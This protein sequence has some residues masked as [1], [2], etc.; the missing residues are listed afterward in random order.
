MCVVLINSELKFLDLIFLLDVGV[1]GV[2]GLIVVIV[3]VGVCILIGD[4]L[5]FGVVVL[6]CNCLVVCCLNCF[7]VCYI[8]VG[9]CGVC[10]ILFV[11]E[12]FVE[13]WL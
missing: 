2:I 3:G 11:W 13:S 4:G 1:V 10:R 5:G 7:Y 9:M 12:I 6:F 8:V